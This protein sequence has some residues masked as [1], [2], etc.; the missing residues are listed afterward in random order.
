MMGNALKTLLRRAGGV[1]RYIPFVNH[2]KLSGAVLSMA[3]GSLMLNTRICCNGKR[4]IIEVENGCTLRNC[5]IQIKGNCNTVKIGKEVRAI[6][7]DICI[8]DDGNT[9]KIGNKT[10]LLGR[11]HLACIEGT[12]ISI[13]DDCLCSSD[14]VVRTGD[15][16]SILDKTGNRI[17][18]SKSV[19]IGNH[20]WIGHNVMLNKGTKIGSNSVVGTGAIVTKPFDENGVILAGIPAKIV[21]NEINW[22]IARL[23]LG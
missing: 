8:E 19:S 2:I 15:S 16:H 22:D 6:N 12:Q 3:P 23:D 14:I 1:T 11:I 7:A 17:N 9:I 13:G 10:K 18:P 20:V 21:K 4:N 5:S